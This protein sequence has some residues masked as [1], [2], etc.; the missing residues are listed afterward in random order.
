MKKTL[1]AFILLCVLTACEDYRD[2]DV[3]GCTHVHEFTVRQNDWKRAVDDTGVYYYCTFREKHLPGS[4]YD[5][6]VLQAYY[7]FDG[8]TALLPFEDFW[9]DQRGNEYTEHFTAEFEPGYVTFIFKCSDHS[10]TLPFYPSY[11]FEVRFVW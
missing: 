9:I 10:D 8:R 7:K 1:F 2:Y 3:E 5:R 6:A 11:T 4:I